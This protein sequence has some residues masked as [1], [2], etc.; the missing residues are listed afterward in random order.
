MAEDVPNRAHH[1]QTSRRLK[2]GL[3]VTVAVLAALALVVLINWLGYSHYTRTDLT[4]SARYS[5]SPQTQKLLGNIEKKH[6][7]V[8]LFGLRNLAD[9]G[10]RKQLQRV[11]DLTDEYDR[12]SGHVEVTHIDPDYDTERR[13][14]FYKKLSDHFKE[15]T[16]P[17]RLA[18][19]ATRGDAVALLK[20]L[21]DMESTLREV[22]SHSGFTDNQ[23]KH[24]VRQLIVW[25]GQS[26][27]DAID[28][29]LDANL[30]QSLPDYETADMQL[31]IILN[32]ISKNLGLAIDGFD[33]S[34]GR[35]GV[36]NE[37][38]SALLG[39]ADRMKPMRKR[40]Q[41]ALTT[42]NQAAPA[43]RYN[44][45]RETITASQALVILSPDQVRVIPRE[46]FY[47]QTN[48][49]T[50]RGQEPQTPN[51]L[52]LG[53]EK[54]T[55]ALASMHFDQPPM[56]V[57]VYTG[58]Q[59][60]LGRGG[61]YNIIAE[62]LRNANFDVRQWNP[63][64]G[65]RTPMGQPAP[66]SPP[67]EPAKGQAV[68]WVV[69]PIEAS[70]NPFTGMSSGKQQVAAHVQK[71]MKQGENV[72]LIL[73]P[74]LG[75]SMN[76]F[77]PIMQMLKPWGI[78]PQLDHLVLRQVQLP[79]GRTIGTQEHWPTRWPTDHPIAKAMTGLR[80]R[81]PLASPIKLEN[82][83]KRQVQ[84]WPLVQLH[85][86]Q[87]WAEDQIKS[88]NDI[89]NAAFDKDASADTFTVG[90][91][92][93]SHDQRLIVVADSGWANDEVTKSGTFFPGNSELFVNSVYWLA[94]LDELIAATPP[95][96]GHSADRADE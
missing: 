18:I 20:Q 95:H 2:Y 69:L 22:A 13:D 80:A 27:A 61:H 66:P 26:D 63:A 29:S 60:A 21:S 3:N 68:V 11:I 59:P 14:E 52:F 45:L 53:E 36:P 1:T 7:I 67:P 54:I 56:V 70:S 37:V 15:Q 19:E 46:E 84:Q 83:K 10:V 28:K 32:Q 34:Y 43:D 6:E 39:L 24:L 44:Q 4:S 79:D 47:R 85:G 49:Q 40:A 94:G 76:N 65:G 87:M 88:A 71:R 93:Q 12:Y 30:K 82:S 31:S 41:Q 33:R 92:A 50:A 64:G 48:V 89:T 77:D 81:F 86:D 91:A 17:T 62:Q 78:K 35:S 51:T 42:L 9:P 73:T 16:K 57:F 74:E 55:G 90:V 5:L 75:G 58:P 96:A 25:T 8:T 72:L 38:Q 23:L